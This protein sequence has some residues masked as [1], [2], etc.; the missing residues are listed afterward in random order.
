[1]ALLGT[2]IDSR[3]IATIATGGSA[4]FAHGLGADPHLVIAQPEAAGT[5]SAASIP[6]YAV[7]HDATN[8]TVYNV[9][10]ANAGGVSAIR[11]VSLRFHSIIQ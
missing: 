6:M 4:T 11:V 9:G 7:A 5:A 8:V 3:T 2:F 1:M 10:Q